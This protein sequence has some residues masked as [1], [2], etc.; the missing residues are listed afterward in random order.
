MKFK[1]ATFGMLNI[2]YWFYINEPWLAFA[3]MCIVVWVLSGD[4]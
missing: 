1:V 3:C 2:I 4:D